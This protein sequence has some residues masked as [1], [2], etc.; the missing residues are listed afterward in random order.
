MHFQFQLLVLTCNPLVATCASRLKLFS[1]TAGVPP[2]MSA[3]REQFF[4]SKYFPHGFAQKVEIHGCAK[5][6]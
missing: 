1:G 2:A 5:I 3:Q 6:G 4:L